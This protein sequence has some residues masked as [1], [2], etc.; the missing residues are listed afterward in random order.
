MTSKLVSTTRNLRYRKARRRRGL[1][2]L[3]GVRLVEEALAADMV[4]QGVLVSDDASGADRIARVLKLFEA[5]GTPIERIP[6]VEF[7]EIAETE[8]PQGIVAV[9]EQP[10]LSIQEIAVP[11]DGLVLA[12]DAVQDPGNVGSMIR[13]AHALGVSGV[14]LLP[15]SADL[16]NSKV[17]RAAMGASFKIPVVTSDHADFG[18]WCTDCNLEV[19]VGTMKGPPVGSLALGSKSRVLV[20][21]NEGAGLSPELLEMVAQEVSIPIDGNSES[22]NVAIAAGILMYEFMKGCHA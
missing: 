13:T 19:W 21:G 14:V 7:D 16:W 18:T 9:V 4:F 1:A 20:V 15:G 12:L 17:L 10:S 11:A 6:K 22:L 8:T 5:R 2:V 3:E